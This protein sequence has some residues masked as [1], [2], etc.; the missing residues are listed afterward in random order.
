MDGALHRVFARQLA[1]ATDAAGRVDLDRLGALVSEAYADAERDHR[2]VDRAMGLMAEEL[3]AANRRLQHLVEEL[4]LQN[5][6]IEAT[7]EN[8]SL[9]VA[10]FDAG[11]RLVVANSQLAEVLGLPPEAVRTGMTYRDA[12]AEGIKAG[13]FPGRDLDTLY[14]E[15]RRTFTPGNSRSFEEAR[16]DRI[17]A[18]ATRALPGGGCVLT[19]QDMTERRRAEARIE[20]MARHDA[21]T[22]LANR[23]EL[24]TRLDAAL[25][26]SR[27]GEG[28]A[29][30]YLDLDRFKAVNDTLGH[31]VG[32]ELLRAVTGRLRGLVRETDLVARLGGDEFA[33]IQTRAEQPEA[34][35]ALARRLVPEISAPYDIEGQQVVIGTSVGIALAPADGATPDALLKAADLALYRAKAEGRGTWRFFAPEMDARMQ[36]RRKLELDLRRAL[37]EGDL[38]LLYQPQIDTASGRI[39]GFEAL[40]RWHDEERGVVAP[41][42]FVPVAEETGLI[43]PIGDWVLRTACREA[44]TWPA[45]VTVAV[46]VSAVQF[47]NET[48]VETVKQALAQAGLPGR[49]LEVEVTEGVMLQDT[50]ATLAIL[51]RLRALGVRISMDDFGT[52]YSSLS[53][54]R[55]FPFDK[56]KIDQSFIRDLGQGGDARAIVR[57]IAGLSGSLGMRTSAEGVETP[58]QYAE[59]QAEGCAEVQ[60][61][62]FGRPV[63]SEVAREM[64]R[65]PAARAGAPGAQDAA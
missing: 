45:E 17:V 28:F 23:S 59:L 34:A 60:G 39:I 11:E 7:L 42:E 30:L 41:A 14:A 1:K 38:K 48:L 24:R 61:F 35:T 13:H 53:Y 10:M 12:L 16:G 43:I 58:A 46:N 40:L 47:R 50:A 15:R 63:P 56:I 44:A 20:H 55:S 32:D 21:L 51:H 36:A 54:L 18:T 37:A 57:A 27:R 65:L 29:L 2:R 52:G 26:R 8:L 25:A 49:R 3:Q 5:Q 33:I 9:G 62:L 19:F 31:P 4:R 22:G 6:R 64:L